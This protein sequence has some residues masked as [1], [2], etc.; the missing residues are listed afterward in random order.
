MTLVAV[1]RRRA[2]R[3]RSPLRALLPALAALA[4]C[5]AFEDSTLPPEGQLVL[6]VDT[7]AIVPLGPG[8]APDATTPAPLFD[9]L[10]VSMF[11]PG[12]SVPCAGCTRE[13]PVTRAAFAEGRVSVGL[14]P[15]AGVAGYRARVALYRSGGSL[16]AARAT[17]TLET[18][19]ALPTTGAEGITTGHVVLLTTDVGSPQG[20]L[21]VPLPLPEGAPGPSRVDGFARA[22]RRGCAGAPREGEV[23]VPGGAFWMGDLSASV[24][25]E[26]L[27][28]VSPYFLDRTEVTVGRLRAAPLARELRANVNYT[29]ASAASPYCTY[30]PS[31]EGREGMPVACVTYEIAQR[32]CEE[33]GGRLPTEAEL[34]YVM[35]G[36]VG[37]SFVWG[38][39]VPGCTDAV[40]AR[41][42][43]SMPD[44]K[45]F[46]ARL[47]IGPSNVATSARDVLRVPGGELFDL[48]G[49]VSEFTSDDFADAENPCWSGTTVL[50]DP[51]CRTGGPEVAFRGT[52]WT[53]SLGESSA[54]GRGFF[55]RDV[56]GNNIGFRCAR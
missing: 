44:G 28:V 16:A 46:C 5:R 53:S 49:N 33:A 17:S 21:E 45:R 39:D 31:P 48:S 4:S 42:L 55:E 8:E 12:E 51:R 36:R 47:G 24:P 6:H 10:T 2:S 52:D 20:S 1:A 19:V 15:R 38:N 35:S 56:V 26:R 14:V 34:A 3:W 43:P 37:T 11:A 32:F 29:A 13:F 54:A 41:G 27:V 23:C 30:S 18:V 25:S 7:D 9:R 22:E 50:V 40:L